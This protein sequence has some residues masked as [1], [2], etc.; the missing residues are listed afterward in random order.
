MS[1]RTHTD[2][3]TQH[4]QTTASQLFYNNCLQSPISTCVHT[5]WCSDSHFLC[6]HIQRHLPLEH[7]C[8][9][10]REKKAHRQSRLPRTLVQCGMIHSLFGLDFNIGAGD[11]DERFLE[12]T[13]PPTIPQQI[14]MWIFITFIIIANV[15]LWKE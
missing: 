4:K 5:Q 13:C 15:S 1:A 12:L 10:D 9:G 6:D 7:S 14:Q 3:C 2:G 8:Q 11:V